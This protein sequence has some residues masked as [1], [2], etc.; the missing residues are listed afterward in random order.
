V[1]TAVL[2]L[3]VLGAA[4]AT[5]STTVTAPQPGP[6]PLLHV[7]AAVRPA[8]VPAGAA[9]VEHKCAVIFETAS[10]SEESVHC[11]D[12][13]MF[14]EGTT[15][16][17]WGGNEVLCQTPAGALRDC[18]SIREHSELS[19]PEFAT[20]TQSG[21]CGTAVGHS[22][23]G[24]R[25]V[26]NVTGSIGVNPFGDFVCSFAGIASDDIVETSDGTTAAGTVTSNI[27]DTACSMQ[28]I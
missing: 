5:A 10:K 1:A 23:C 7:P 2:S 20:R 19:S 18:V 22:D 25:R 24:A 13:W 14:S 28:V 3:G 26:E 9:L 16:L 21:I 17:I 6:P 8:A 4:P 11:A 12:V 15:N 27:F